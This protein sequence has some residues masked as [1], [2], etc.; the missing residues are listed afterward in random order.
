MA[1]APPPG[2]KSLL[3]CNR[4]KAL[5]TF[6]EGASSSSVSVEESSPDPSLDPERRAANTFF[7]LRELRRGE[8]SLSATSSLFRPQEIEAVWCSLAVVA[9]ESGATHCSTTMQ[10][11]PGV[12]EA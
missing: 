11:G 12:G 3:S 10:S 9:R 7:F 4:V 8:W 5:L 1:E 6:G 2:F